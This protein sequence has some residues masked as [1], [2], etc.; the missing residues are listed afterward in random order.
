MDNDTKPTS[1]SAGPEE[2]TASGGFFSTI[3]TPGSSLSPTSLLVLDGAFG[4]LLL[5]LF[6]LFVI[7]HGNLHLLFL[8]VIECCLWGSV[9]WFVHELRLA[10][11]QEAANNSGGDVASDDAELKQKQE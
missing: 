7:T 2:E 11:A 10:Q 1:P 3:L 4:S 6:S 9:K 5:V 8:M